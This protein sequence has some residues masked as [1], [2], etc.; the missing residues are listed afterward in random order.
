MYPAV[1]HTKVRSERRQGGRSEQ[2]SSPHV[3]ERRSGARDDD[4]GLD[5][6]RDGTR[7]A[8]AMQAH[9]EGRLGPCVRRPGFQPW[10]V[11][12]GHL[13]FPAAQVGIAIWML[14][15][16]DGKWHEMD[17]RVGT[18]PPGGG[19]GKRVTAKA[20]CKDGST[21]TWHSTASVVVTGGSD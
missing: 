5:G 20:P 11:G 18:V 9:R 7:D 6:D 17:S 8:A 14:W 13:Q 1:R 4:H 19:A 3:A 12:A 15:T 16:S 21:R 2:T 10:L